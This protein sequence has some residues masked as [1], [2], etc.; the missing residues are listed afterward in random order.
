MAKVIGLLGLLML[1]VGGLMA[2]IIMG[3][4]SPTAGRPEA[5]IAGVG[6]ILAYMSTLNEKPSKNRRG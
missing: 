4:D 2:A 3:I 6:L 1:M 5:V